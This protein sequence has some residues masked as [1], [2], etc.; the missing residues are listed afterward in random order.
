[1]ID[2]TTAVIITQIPIALAILFAAYE[3]NQVKKDLI[4]IL[5]KHCP[6]WRDIRSELNQLPLAAEFFL[7]N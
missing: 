2:T 7:K 6:L 4:K 3:L 5:D 1:M